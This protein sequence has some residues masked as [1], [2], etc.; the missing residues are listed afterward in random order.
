MEPS[1][2][3]RQETTKE[4]KENVA[5]SRGNENSSM[6]KEKNT[7][8]R[9][10]VP[11]SRLSDDEEESKVVDKESKR[12]KS[13]LISE[14]SERFWF[15][16]PPNTTNTSADLSE[17]KVEQHSLPTIK[18]QPILGGKPLY[19]PVHPRLTLI[20][21][22][23]FILFSLN[24]PHPQQILS[25]YNETGKKV[26]LLSNYSENTLLCTIPGLIDEITGR[27]APVSLNF[28]MLSG[29]DFSINP[30]DVEYENSGNTSD[31]EGYFELNGTSEGISDDNSSKLSALAATLASIIPFPPGVTKSSKMLIRSL[32]K[33]SPTNS[34][35]PTLWEIYFPESSV[36]MMVT[37]LI[38]VNEV[39]S[40]D[41]NEKTENNLKS[42]DVENEKKENK[43]NDI[44]IENENDHNEP[45]TPSISFAAPT[46]LITDESREKTTC[47][48]LPLTLSSE[49][50]AAVDPKTNCEKCRVRCRP[51]LRFICKCHKTFCQSHRYPD[52]HDCT[53]DHR[54]DGMATIQA[55][56][57]KIVKDKVG[58]F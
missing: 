8:K 40:D 11:V 51:A 47:E 50:L 46:L 43:N 4:D 58:N 49:S 6:E 28:K 41:E 37:A 15:D 56:N 18:I 16:T 36:K 38:N 52:K 24:I 13:S 14:S 3:N 5:E 21:L 25:F 30:S 19:F 54:A 39:K 2:Q 1:D 55:N 7:M 26:I 23:D 12:L 29:M 48:P 10:N 34:N 35:L 57:P 42:E 31:S 17:S 45:T 20:D 9:R 32:S 27:C 53:F 22:K 44:V 33:S